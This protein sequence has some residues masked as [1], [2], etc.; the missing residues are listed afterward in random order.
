M[1]LP[2]RLTFCNCCRYS[3]VRS[4]RAIKSGK[5]PSLLFCYATMFFSSPAADTQTQAQRRA[6]LERAKSM[7][8]PSSTTTSSG[9]GLGADCNVP[10]VTTYSGR[11]APHL[12]PP[13][14]G[15]LISTST[16]TDSHFQ[17]QVHHSS[18]VGC[19]TLSAEI[20]TAATLAATQT[21]TSSAYLASDAQQQQQQ[22][23]QSSWMSQ[24]R[25]APGY[26]PAVADGSFVSGTKGPSWVSTNPS[27]CAS[28][29]PLDAAIRDFMR[30]SASERNPFRR[31]SECGTI[32]K[33]GN[34]SFN[35]ASECGT[36]AAFSHVSFNRSSE[37]GTSATVGHVSFNRASEF[38][39]STM[40]D[41]V[42]FNRASGC[43]MSHESSLASRISPQGY[44]QEVI[45][46]SQLQANH[47][48]GD[49]ADYTAIIPEV[50]SL[51]L[52]E[53]LD[54]L[55]ELGE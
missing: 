19:T 5:K 12:P 44:L 11:S 1:Y 33:D 52:N 49:A 42:S 3:T 29:R 7:A 9:G 18:S 38:S 30:M 23:Q 54:M 31:A 8:S 39:T 51:D 15:L 50:P 17:P 48:A 20:I 41:C 6:L 22:Q 46:A 36:S 32:S 16:P 26:F 55:P 4:K 40:T 37:C 28:D 10:V 34:I 53:L 25:S 14:P 21:T 27:T 43:G 45:E 35:R 13:L 47:E 2:N 24:R